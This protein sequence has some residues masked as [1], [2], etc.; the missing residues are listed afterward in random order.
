MILLKRNRKSFSLPKPKKKKDYDLTW[1]Y[2][3]PQRSDFFGSQKDWNQT[4]ITKINQCSAQ[5]NKESLKGWCK[6]D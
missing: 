5:L 6:Y 4:L 2:K 1:D 3:C